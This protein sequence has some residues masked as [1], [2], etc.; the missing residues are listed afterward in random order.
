M[1][2]IANSKEANPVIP[3]GIVESDCWCGRDVTC[4]VE[5]KSVLGVIALVIAAA[6]LIFALLLASGIFGGGETGFIAGGLTV[7][8]MIS[9]AIAAILLIPRPGTGTG[10]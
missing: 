2:A 9:L 4:H 7:G 1:A 5:T 6:M 10:R 8:T 3:K